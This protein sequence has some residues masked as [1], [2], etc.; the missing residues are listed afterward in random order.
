MPKTVYLLIAYDGTDFHGWQRQPGLRTVQ[1]VLEDSIQ[2]VVRHPIE[3]IGSGR[4][5]AGV[6]AAGQ[7]AS[8]S[9]SSSAPGD[10]LR[11]AIG[12]RLSDDL[13]VLDSREVHPDF[14]ATKSAL[15][16]LYRYRIH[17]A[18][19]RPVAHLTQRYAY[20]C[21]KNLDLDRMRQ[22]SRHF[23]GEMDFLAM[24][25]RG[26]PR[27]TTVRTVLGCDIERHIDEVRIDVHGTGFLYNQVRNMVG[28]LL[29]VGL[30]RWEPDYVIEILQSRD[31]SNA[32]RTMPACG[33][34]LQWV[35]YPAALFVAPQRRSD[36]NL[37][38]EPQSL[39]QN[40]DRA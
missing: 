28:T 16:K 10:K 35:R 23:I 37:S 4:T 1:G 11:H 30:G 20:H 17:H 38:Q 15:S 5:D 26:K 24:A 21:W 18:K 2:R 39:P 36:D 40:H 19:T 27:E 3:L 31:R 32:G 12:S 13:A 6:H 7:V 34:C 33:L 22:A 25:S 9:T 8:F 14:H 29:E